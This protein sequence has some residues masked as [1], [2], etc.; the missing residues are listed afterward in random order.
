MILHHH[1]AS[2]NVARI[3]NE[4]FIWACATANNGM[5]S[6]HIPVVWLTANPDDVFTTDADREFFRRKGWDDLAAD[7]NRH[8]YAGCKTHPGVTRITIKI[9]NRRKRVV[10]PYYE[11]LDEVNPELGRHARAY[12]AAAASHRADHW[13]LCLQD[14][15]TAWIESVESVGEES[16]EY[17]RIGKAIEATGTYPA[18]T[19]HEDKNPLLTRALDAA[20]RAQQPMLWTPP[21]VH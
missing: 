1:T 6:A 15:P 20:M 14:I 21:T 13:W 16:A 18:A 3:M 9:S 8:Y 4:G 19:L 7:P 11:F 5:M 10:A 12:S 17:S 2:C